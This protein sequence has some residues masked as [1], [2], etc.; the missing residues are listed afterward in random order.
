MKR[1]G[2]ITSLFVFTAFVAVFLLAATTLKSVSLVQESD[3]ERVS[4]MKA[5][6]V[7]HNLEYLM[8]ALDADGINCSEVQGDIEGTRLPFKVK[9]DCYAD[10]GEIVA[11]NLRSCSYIYGFRTD[12][13]GCTPIDCAALGRQCGSDGCGGSC[14]SCGTGEFCNSTWQCESGVA[15][16]HAPSCGDGN[17]DL[18]ENCDGSDLDGHDCLSKGYADGGT[19]SCYPPG[20]LYECTFDTSLCTGSPPTPSCE[21]NTI[22]D[23]SCGSNCNIIHLTGSNIPGEIGDNFGYLNSPFS[24][25]Y[26]EKVSPSNLEMFCD[27]SIGSCNAGT[28]HSGVW[29]TGVSIIKNQIT[30]GAWVATSPSS[31][32][33]DYVG[34]PGP[35]TSVVGCRDG[36]REAFEDIIL[37]PEIAGCAGSWTKQSLRATGTGSAEDFCADDWHICTR[38]GDLSELRNAA[39]AEQCIAAG[40]GTFAAASSHCSKNS[41]VSCKYDDLFECSASGI[42]FGRCSEAICCGNGCGISDCKDAVWPDSTHAF[43]PGIVSNGCSESVT[44]L[45]KWTGV[46]CCKD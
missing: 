28:P 13:C 36:T 17:I 16:P 14:G 8:G 9:L 23:S 3:Y 7:A 21:I 42:L 25:F 4:I 43:S 2:Y 39:T 35:P 6:R 22:T 18:G 31:E 34:S 32:S 38:D 10:V 41:L 37:F 33:C 15:P 12:E 11:V 20:S 19:L 1:K 45:N 44:V 5:A 29:N 40:T 46:L 27:V 30:T 26:F 24:Q